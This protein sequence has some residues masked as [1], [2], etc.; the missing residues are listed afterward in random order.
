MTILNKCIADF[1]E[2]NEAAR[3]YTQMGDGNKHRNFTS[4]GQEII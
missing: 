1:E 3:F 4:G 2:T